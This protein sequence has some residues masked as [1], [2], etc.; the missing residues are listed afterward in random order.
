MDGRRDVDIDEDVD[1]VIHGQPAII[2]GVS[3]HN[4]PWPTLIQAVLSDLC[5]LSQHIIA[6]Y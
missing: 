4:P 5:M 1:K 2:A 3:S 6:V